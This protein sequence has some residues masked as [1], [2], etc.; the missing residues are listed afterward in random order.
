MSIYESTHLFVMTTIYNVSPIWSTRI[1]P[2]FEWDDI[3]EQK[4]DGSDLSYYSN[5]LT[6][7][8]SGWVHKSEHTGVS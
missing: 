4:S 5:S 6:I 2:S 3:V 7:E 1:K 8:R